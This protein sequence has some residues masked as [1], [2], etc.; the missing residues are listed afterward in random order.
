MM[1]QEIDSANGC[2]PECFQGRSANGRWL[3]SSVSASASDV[4]RA[5]ISRV[6]SE[7]SA[8]DYSYSKGPLDLVRTH[9]LWNELWTVRVRAV[10][11]NEAATSF[12]HTT[13]LIS[14]M[15]FCCNTATMQATLDMLCDA[16][17]TTYPFSSLLPALTCPQLQL[18]AL[19][20]REL[21]DILQLVRFYEEV[22]L[23]MTCFMHAHR[24]DSV[25]W[26]NQQLQH[27]ACVLSDFDVAILTCILRGWAL[28]ASPEERAR[29]RDTIV[30]GDS[31]FGRHPDDLL[32]GLPEHRQVFDV[33][34]TLFDAA[35]QAWRLV[36]ANTGRQDAARAR[37][38]FDMIRAAV[39][40]LVAGVAVNQE[41][42][43]CELLVHQHMLVLGRVCRPLSLLEW[44]LYCGAENAARCYAETLNGRNVRH[45]HP[46]TDMLLAAGNMSSHVLR[47]RELRWGAKLSIAVS[48]SEQ[49]LLRLVME[50]AE[51]HAVAHAST[52]YE[53]DGDMR[54]FMRSWLLESVRTARP[55]NGQ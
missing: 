50:L 27:L 39:A 17:T 24:H 2:P 15:L 33:V 14:Y 10:H 22:A 49:S 19:Q 32:F 26:A 44:L 35:S 18:G 41:D 47:L 42:L 28:E 8:L 1:R 40:K 31:P 53:G 45:H 51:P 38:P 16:K 36:D 11:I 30:C 34:R 48:R 46:A 29:I 21:R 5:E 52:E 54:R 7:G 13:P 20:P 3:S 6:V 43:L 9:S 4:A 37:V 25:R 12:G 23:D 55:I